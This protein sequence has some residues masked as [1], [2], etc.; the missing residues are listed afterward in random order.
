M[1]RRKST[2]KDR[3]F[4]ILGVGVLLYGTV[5]LSWLAVRLVVTLV[6]GGR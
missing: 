1:T 3:C 6:F 4:Q 5:I 2:F